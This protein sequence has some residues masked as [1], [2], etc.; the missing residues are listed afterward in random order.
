MKL[1][2]GIDVSS[3]KLDACFLTSDQEILLE[4]TYPN[5]TLGALDVKVKLLSLFPKS[6]TLNKLLLVWNRLPC[7]A[8]IQP[9]IF[10]WMTTYNRSRQLHRK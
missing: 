6:M 2:V 8:F 7:T 3:E 10:N 5:D 9:C 1:F 4:S